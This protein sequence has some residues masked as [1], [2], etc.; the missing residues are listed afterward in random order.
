MFN[1]RL[2]RLREWRNM[3][4]KELGQKL[5]YTQQTIHKWE[6]GEAS[7][8]P[9]ILIK[10]ADAL[11]VPVAMLVGEAMV[12]EGSAAYQS[13]EDFIA[14]MTQSKTFISLFELD[15]SLSQDELN[16]LSHQLYQMTL[17]LT[18]PI[19]KNNANALF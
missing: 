7:P 3:T 1:A 18:N 19:N 13:A 9:D 14:A 11:Q 10:I 15:Q 4:Q 2:K 16:L 12:E 17:V 5:N 6:V 8:D